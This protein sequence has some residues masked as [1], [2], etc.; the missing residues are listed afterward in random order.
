MKGK[1]TV[2]ETEPLDGYALMEDKVIEIEENDSIFISR[3]LYT[4]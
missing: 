1:Y 4:K 2:K 3:Y